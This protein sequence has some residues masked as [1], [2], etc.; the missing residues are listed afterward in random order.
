MIK[1]SVYLNFLILAALALG[2]CS[3]FWPNQALFSTADIV[4]KLFLKFLKL[5]SL[6]LIFL[7]LVSSISSMRSLKQMRVIGKKILTYTLSTT[8]VAATIGLIFYLVIH[9]KISIPQN[10]HVVELSGSYFSFLFDMVPENFVQVFLEN[11]VMGGAFLGLILGIA[12][13]YLPEKNKETLNDFFQS[14]FSAVLKIT[15]GLIFIIPIGV[16]AFV[17]LFVQELSQN[18]GQYQSLM[19]YIYAVVGANLVQG[20]IVLPLLLKYKGLSP[21]KTFKGMAPA[22]FTAFFTKSSNATMPV[23][24]KCAEQNLKIDGKLVKLSIPLCSVI[25][26][27]ACAAFILITTLF[28]SGSYGIQFTLLEMGF[29]TIL[30]TLAAVGN[31]GV[32]MGCYFLTSAFLVGMNVPLTIMGL[33]L[34]FYTLLDMLETAINVWSDSCISQIVDKDLKESKEALI[35]ESTV[36]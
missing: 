16:W 8:L 33:I 5:L 23:A 14:L 25:N 4:G 26:M 31:A 13:L 20:L 29:W 36:T 7:A 3:Y 10:E 12:I 15:E 24:M 18:Q 9:P 28:V 30:A 2:A 34:P 22:L 19:Y 32:P 27:N 17:T 6:P 11:N 1:K 35:P 21:W